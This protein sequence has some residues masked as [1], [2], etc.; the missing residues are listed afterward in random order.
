[1]FL[2][3]NAMN[4]AESIIS[5]EDVPDDKEIQGKAD[6]TCLLKMISCDCSQLGR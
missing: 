6:F 4:L 2:A 5:Y 3:P 1:M